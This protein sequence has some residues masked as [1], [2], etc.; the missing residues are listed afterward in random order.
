M[1]EEGAFSQISKYEGKIQLETEKNI[2]N[3]KAIT[4]IAKKFLEKK[5]KKKIQEAIGLKKDR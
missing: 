5:M 3:N 4:M 1:L 2:S